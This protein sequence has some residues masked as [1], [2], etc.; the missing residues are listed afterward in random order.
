MAM[1][2]TLVVVY[3]VIRAGG[4]GGDTVRAAVF[5]TRT[6]DLVTNT[7]RLALTVTVLS[8]LIGVGL[9]VGVSRGVS[10]GRPIWVTMPAAPLAIPSYIAGF[11]W[12]RLIPGFERFGAAV[13]ILTMTC[14][15]L[16]MLP[17]VAALS[18]TGR[19]AED[20]ARTLGCTPWWPSCAPPGPGSPRRSSVG[21]CWWRCMRS[22]TSVDR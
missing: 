5:R 4:A 2:V 15:P 3:L 9:A 19:S 12:G 14:Y 20:V 22:A 7:A 18:G 16:V 11:A 21:H 8:V 17:A 6:L 13:L 1:L 10:R